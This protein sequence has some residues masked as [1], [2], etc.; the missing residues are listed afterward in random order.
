MTD[1][2]ISASIAGKDVADMDKN[3]GVN[4][5]LEL[6]TNVGICVRRVAKQITP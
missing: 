6:D 5:V 1:G 4:H 2:E 3:Q